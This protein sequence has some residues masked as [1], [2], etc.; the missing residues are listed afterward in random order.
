MTESGSGTAQPVDLGEMWAAEKAARRFYLGDRSKMEIAAEMGVSRFKVAR[1]LD[2]AH[3]SG[4]VTITIRGAGEVDGDLSLAV[5]DRFALRDVL[6]LSSPDNA[7]DTAMREVL[8]G[9]AAN[10]LSS[11]LDRHDVLGLGWARAVLAMVANLATLPPCAVVQLS[12]ALMRPD[13]EPDSIELVRNV[14][15]ISGGSASFFYAPMIADTPAAAR[16]IRA[17]SDVAAARAK[18]DTVTTAV[19]GVGGWTPAASTLSQALT[20]PERSVVLRSGVYTDLSG[21]LLDRHGRPA[22]TALNERIIGITAAQ[23]RAIP[24]VI[25]IAYGV[26]KVGPAHAAL[27]G[28]YVNSLVTHVSFARAL[29]GYDPGTR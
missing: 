27:T 29:L 11:V 5:Q 15:R 7:D 28:G 25:G 8:G 2:L 22:R 24:N 16:S 17:Q 23:L 14:A 6:V 21:V 4:M 12:G 20:A 1:L 13:V 9:A 19:V 18:Y 26:D 3:S 10:L